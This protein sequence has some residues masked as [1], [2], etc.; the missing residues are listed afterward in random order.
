M[1][2]G[3]LDYFYATLYDHVGDFNDKELDELVKDLS[4]LF[5]EREWYLS[6]DTCEGDWNDARDAF[7]KRWFTD[8]GRAERIEKILS[9]TME[10]IK[11]SFGLSKKYCRNCSYWTPK[12]N[13]DHGKCELKGTYL[14]HRS[15]S[16]AL[17]KAKDDVKGV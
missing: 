9:E 12:E 10:E 2:G 16:C 14:L 6:G 11:K 8:E 15:E 17:W 5:H 4:D 7:K 1:S 13:S 3:R